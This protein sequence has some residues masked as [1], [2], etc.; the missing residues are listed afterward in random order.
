MS[1]KK[2]TGTQANGEK[3]FQPY[4]TATHQPFFA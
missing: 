3:K 1:T 4:K 2:M